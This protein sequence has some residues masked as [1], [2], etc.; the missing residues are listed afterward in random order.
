MNRTKR[1][2]ALLL[3]FATL[4]VV[5][6]AASA[7]KQVAPDSGGVPGAVIHSGGVPGAVIHS[8]GVPGVA[9]TFARSALRPK[10][11][12]EGPGCTVK[13]F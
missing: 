1:T 5:A 8:G 2:L 9:K 13:Y 12:C 10:P 6:P 3:S 7:A 4:A 11:V